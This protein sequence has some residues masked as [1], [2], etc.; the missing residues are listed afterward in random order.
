MA[1]VVCLRSKDQAF[2]ATKQF[3]S[4]VRTQYNAL[5]KGWRSD[6]GGEF[7]SKAFRDYLKDNG[8]HIHQSAPYAHQQNGHA[9]RLIRTLMDKAQTMYFHTCLPDSYWEFAILH[10]AHVY[11]MMLMNWLNWRTPLELLKGAKPSVSHLRVFRCG[12]YVHLPDETRKGKLQPKS[13]LM[14]YL[15]VSAGSEHNYLFM[16]PNN[17]LHTSAHA[18]FNKHLFS[19]CSGARPHKPVSHVPYNPHKHTPN[20]H[21]SDLEVIDDDVVSQ[22]PP[23]QPPVVQLPVRTPSPAPPA[24]PPPLP[25]AP[26]T[27]P[28]SHPPP[29]GPPPLRRGEQEHRAPFRPGN[30]Y[31]EHGQP[32]KQVKEIEHESTWKR[33]IGEEPPKALDT[34]NIPSGLPPSLIPSEDNVDRLTREGGDSFT[35]YLCSCA[36]P[37]AESANSPN[38]REWSYH[39]IL[40]LPTDEQSL[41]WKTCKTELSM[42]KERK[43]WEVTDRPIDHKIIKNCWVFDVKTDG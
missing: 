37:Y 25:P 20:R 29:V 22:D 43:V 40:K 13:Q 3:V 38:Y 11:N 35:S 34:P 6:A 12:A 9:E 26:V 4:Y 16:H 30:I 23:R 14:V 28:C 31:G 15:G 2:V 42:L 21:E 18:I 41:W 5:I 24:T 36:I 33:L 27:P 32:S 19:K 17:A 39:D 8:I 7:T 10:A 1:W